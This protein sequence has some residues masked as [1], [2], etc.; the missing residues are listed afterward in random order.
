VTCTVRCC[1]QRLAGATRVL[2][3]SAP[4]GSTTAAHPAFGD[5]R[6]RVAGQVSSLAF[7]ASNSSA[8]MTP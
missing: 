7:W 8:L 1:A 4:A 3:R 5:V 6:A 2:A